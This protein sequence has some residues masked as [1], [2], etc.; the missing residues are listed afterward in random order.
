MLLPLVPSTSPVEIK[1]PQKVNMLWGKGDNSQKGSRVGGPVD[2]RMKG[3][4]RDL[5]EYFGFDEEDR[6]DEHNQQQ[7]QRQQ[8]HNQQQQQRQP[9]QAPTTNQPTDRQTGQPT[10]QPTNQ[11]TDR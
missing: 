3:L 6:D 5:R 10:N 7:Q 9:Q 2:D 8:Q 11:P 1:S 4:D